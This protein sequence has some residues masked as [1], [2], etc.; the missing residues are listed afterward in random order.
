[1]LCTGS[2]PLPIELGGVLPVGDSGDFLSFPALLS[3]ALSLIDRES[4]FCSVP[5]RCLYPSHGVCQ[6]HARADKPNIWQLSCEFRSGALI[7][8]IGVTRILPCHVGQLALEGGADV[9][10][11]GENGVFQPDEAQH[12][13]L[14]IAAAEIEILFPDTLLLD[15]GPH[16]VSSA[17]GR[18]ERGLERKQ[19]LL[20][21]PRADSRLSVARQRVHSGSRS[22]E[23]S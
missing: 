14:W 5:T 13:G 20:K 18:P 11:R 21:S 15:E 16:R 10:W 23:R 7:L 8:L 1:M 9:L 6:V 3:G 17:Q 12:D 19:L 22:L 4:N 2:A